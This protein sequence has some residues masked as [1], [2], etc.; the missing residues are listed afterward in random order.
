MRKFII[1]DIHGCFDE[2]IEL[3]QKVGLTADDLLISLGDIVDRGN[4]S[5]DVY[6]YFLNRPNSIVL[7]GNHERKHITNKNRRT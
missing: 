6:E 1:G 7:I 4:K 3:T 2:L 5:K